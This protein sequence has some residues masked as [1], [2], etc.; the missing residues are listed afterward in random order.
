MFRVD[1]LALDKDASRDHVAG[2]YQTSDGAKGQIGLFVELIAVEVPDF[3]FPA[4]RLQIREA[5][6][7]AVS[8]CAEFPKDHMKSLS[9]FVLGGAT[10]G[11]VALPDL[12]QEHPPRH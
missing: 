1:R 3:F 12:L 4:W 11:K 9:D 2:G 6:N 7:S 8:R 10:Y 5:L